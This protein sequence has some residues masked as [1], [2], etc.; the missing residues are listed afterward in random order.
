MA[1]RACRSSFSSGVKLAILTT[2]QSNKKFNL[3]GCSTSIAIQDAAFIATTLLGFNICKASTDVIIPEQTHNF[4][5]YLTWPSCPV[6]HP[7]T[8][9]HLVPWSGPL[10]CHS[11]AMS[12]IAEA[13]TCIPEGVITGSLSLISAGQRDLAVSNLF[14]ENHHLFAAIFI[15]QIESHRKSI[16]KNPPNRFLS[17]L[18]QDAPSPCQGTPYSLAKRELVAIFRCDPRRPRCNSCWWG[19][20]RRNLRQK[21]WTVKPEMVV[22]LPCRN[23]SYQSDRPADVSSKTR[24][25]DTNLQIW[26]VDYGII[27]KSSNLERLTR[28]LG[29]VHTKEP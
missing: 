26:G 25:D 29:Q 11:C 5:Q 3:A 1:E 20:H 2:R 9:D 10:W 27:R 14:L 22:R 12:D 6:K 21:F 17:E 7:S 16:L 23:R 8:H 13:E 28:P 15:S 24:Q 4:L 19:W 18:P